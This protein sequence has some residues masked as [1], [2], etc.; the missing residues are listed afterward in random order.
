MAGNQKPLPEAEIES[1]PARF[2]DAEIPKTYIA[3]AFG[4]VIRTAMANEPCLAANRA[5]NPC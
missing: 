2:P 1:F 5:G 4:E 3:K